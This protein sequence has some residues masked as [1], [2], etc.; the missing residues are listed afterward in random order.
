[1][2]SFQTEQHF[3]GESSV[4][5]GVS[6]SDVSIRAPACVLTLLSKEL[7]KSNYL[8]KGPQK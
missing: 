8:R 5:G 6:I 1:M 3:Y 4:S 2:S 7:G